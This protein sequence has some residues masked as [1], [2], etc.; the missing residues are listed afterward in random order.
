MNDA[1]SKY[2]YQKYDRVRQAID[3]HNLALRTFDLHAG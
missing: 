3:E 2:N 1:Y